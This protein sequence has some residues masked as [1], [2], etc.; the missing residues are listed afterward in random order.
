MRL[1]P[2]LSARRRGTR[3]PSD[4]NKYLP[5]MWED[6]RVHVAD[7]KAREIVG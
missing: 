2:T 4:G 5:D 1:T 6:D 7:C 3:F